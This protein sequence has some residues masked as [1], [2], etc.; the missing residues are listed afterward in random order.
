MA[1]IAE[2]HL[3]QNFDPSNLNRDDTGAPKDAMFGGVKRGRI[4]TSDGVLLAE[5]L[6]GTG[7][8]KYT[9]HYPQGVLYDHVTGYDSP[10][11]G[12]TGIEAG[13]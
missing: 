1:T 4:L 11:F 5:S 6:E 10:Q 9:R 7:E 13:R 3:L 8:I 12:R 2:F